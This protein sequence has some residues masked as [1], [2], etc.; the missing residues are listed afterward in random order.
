VD[1]TGVFVADGRA[2]VRFGGRKGLVFSGDSSSLLWLLC[3]GPEKWWE[4]GGGGSCV[5][6]CVPQ[7]KFFRDWCC[8]DDF[9]VGSS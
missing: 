6:E 7:E 1:L 4:M 9:S 5:S 3:F 8:Y 2:L